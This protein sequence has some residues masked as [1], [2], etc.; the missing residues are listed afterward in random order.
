[1]SKKGV[2]PL[3]NCLIRGEKF[4][5][6]VNGIGDGSGGGSSDILNYD[7]DVIYSINNDYGTIVENILPVTTKE[8][9]GIEATNEDSI[10]AGAGIPYFYNNGANLIL[11]TSTLN[12]YELS[13]PYNIFS[14]TKIEE[15][16][17]LSESIG[18][19]PDYA[20]SLA[21]CQN[22]SPDGKTV[23]IL[24]WNNRIVYQFTLSQAWDITQISVE[25]YDGYF[26]D[27]NRADQYPGLIY[28]VVTFSNDGNKMFLGGYDSDDG[29][30]GVIRCYQL[31]TAWNVV[32]ANEDNLLYET[33]FDPSEIG[34]SEYRIEGLE[35]RDSGSTAYISNKHGDYA[36]IIDGYIEIFELSTPY[37]LRTRKN[38]FTYYSES[39][40]KGIHVSNEQISAKKETLVDIENTRD[41]DM[42]DGLLPG[43]GDA[44][45]EVTSDTATGEKAL[46]SSEV[47]DDAI[48]DCIYNLTVPEN[49]LAALY[50]EW[51]V[52]AE[53][54]DDYFRVFINGVED[55]NYGQPID[56]GVFRSYRKVLPAGSYEIRFVYETDSMGASW[57]DRALIKNLSLLHLTRNVKL[58]PPTGLSVPTVGDGKVFL[59]WNEN[60]EFHAAGY[61]QYVDGEKVNGAKPAYGSN[62]WVEDLEN[63]K[64]YGIGITATDSIG[65]ESEL[66]EIVYAVPQQPTESVFEPVADAWVNESQPE[67]NNNNEIL[68]TGNGNKA[69]IK[70]DISQFPVPEITEAKLKLQIAGDDMASWE[71]SSRTIYNGKSNDW[72]EDTL[73]H[74]NQPGAG[75]NIFSW[76]FEGY[77][78]DPGTIM[79][80]DV[81]DAIKSTEEDVITLVI[82]SNDDIT[83]DFASKENTT[84]AGPE[85][86]LKGYESA[87]VLAAPYDLTATSLTGGMEL[88]WKAPTGMSSVTYDLYIDGVKSNT[89][90][91]SGTTYA[92]DN[93]VNGQQ[94]EFH[95]V[96]VDKYGN[97][98]EQS[99][100]VTA[101]PTADTLSSP[102]NLTSNAFDGGVEL[103]WGYSGMETV[104]YD[105]YVDGNKI[106]SNPIDDN[107]YIVENLNNGQEYEFYVVAID[108]LGN[109]SQPSDTILETPLAD[110]ELAGYSLSFDGTQYVD[111]GPLG[112]FG[113]DY[114][115][116]HSVEATIQTTDISDMWLFGVQQISSQMQWFL[117]LNQDGTDRLRFVVRSNNAGSYNVNAIDAR[118]TA[119]G[120]T[121]GQPHT[122]SIASDRLTADVTILFDG[123]P[124]SISYENN[125]TIDDFGTFD[126]GVFLGGFSREGVLEGGYTGLVNEF[127][128]WSKL[129]TQ[130]DVQNNM[131]VQLDPNNYPDLF[132]YYPVNNGQGDILTEEVAGD[133]GTLYGNENDNM[134]E[135]V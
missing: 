22:F 102:I 53:R 99:G 98:T 3:R 16:D 57:E 2:I 113:S 31:P 18:A 10:P 114:I 93:L 111:L 17:V 100:I 12:K 65:N 126:T 95:V 41:G 101:A 61:N 19:N 94:Y 135:T 77:D 59:A 8:V 6:Q 123:S 25:K 73:T 56:A 39:A 72:G 66:S 89:D 11:K 54:Y 50:F 60:K 7:A 71:Q 20:M 42:P 63:N 130:Q 86:Y 117:R 80:I 68:K 81:L 62:T 44:N 69:Y 110:V 9:M 91:I 5:I 34:E 127:R 70:L 119:P 82:S 79:E 55:F 15:S 24:E 58:L 51:R 78:V 35:F 129:I 13:I 27:N 49:T 85:L 37:D 43:I 87:I 30:A 88:N 23:Y 29:F 104:K 38:R 115:Q 116:L 122:I 32:D 124:L 84:Y 90:P 97:E 118:A 45:W 112:N 108:L 105:V 131:G 132:R 40:P 121:D 120:L 64:V 125:G 28:S 92:V 33:R 74:N 26:I 14:A 96:G 4:G 107:T 103:T 52:S 36:E 76:D 46:R 134:W 48:A 67:T 75:T 83:I 1:M 106:N 133:N 128:V 21:I 47:G 109:E